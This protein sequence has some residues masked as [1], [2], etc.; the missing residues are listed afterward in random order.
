MSNCCN[1]VYSL[2]IKAVEMESDFVVKYYCCT[3]ASITAVLISVYRQMSSSGDKDHN[4]ES[5]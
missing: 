4:I 5:D 1:L 2:S 3:F